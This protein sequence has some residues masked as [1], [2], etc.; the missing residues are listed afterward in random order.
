MTLTKFQIGKLGI[1]QGV[2]NSLSLD[3]KTHTQVRISLLKSAQEERKRI[4]EIALE[5]QSKLPVK[6]RL[7]IIGFTIILT[8][9]SNKKV[10]SKSL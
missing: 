9:L 4:K 5:I 3:L 6:T 10:Q 2:L 1:T 8:K 7:R